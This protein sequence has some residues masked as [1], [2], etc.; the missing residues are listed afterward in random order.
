M[1]VFQSLTAL[2]ALQWEPQVFSGEE[3]HNICVSDQF[4]I[5]DEDREVVLKL[6]SV[7]FLPRKSVSPT[8]YT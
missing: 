1:S 3:Q 5:R 8:T 7:L 6:R 4:D 2:V